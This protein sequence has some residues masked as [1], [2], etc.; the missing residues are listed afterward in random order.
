MKSIRREEGEEGKGTGERKDILAAQR[1]DVF[2]AFEIVANPLGRVFVLEGHAFLNARE[3][4]LLHF[5]RGCVGIRG[6]VFLFVLG[7]RV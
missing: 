6:E 3:V 7:E 2:S 5:L 4:G 1:I